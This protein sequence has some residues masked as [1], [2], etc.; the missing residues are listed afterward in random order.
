M[1]KYFCEKCEKETHEKANMYSLEK[2]VPAGTLNMRISI[3]I[4]KENKEFPENGDILVP[5]FLCKECIKEYVNIS[6]AIG[7]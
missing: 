1:I 6:N 3:S 4:E 5:G 2:D 7:S